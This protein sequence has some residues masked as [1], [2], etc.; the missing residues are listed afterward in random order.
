ME[1]I[2]EIESELFVASITPLELTES[3]A[4]AMEFNESEVDD[5]LEALNGSETSFAKG[6]PTDR[7][8]H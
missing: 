7:Q 2:Y 1:T 4:D 5:V 6:R 3:E 8:P